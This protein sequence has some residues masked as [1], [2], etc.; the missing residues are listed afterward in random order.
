[1][2]NGQVL[3]AMLSRASVRK[4]RQ[5]PVS[6]EVLRTIVR[7]G[8]QAPF[9]G[10]MYSVIVATER[11][12]R[13]RL[14][15]LF[16]SLVVQAPVFMLI[17]VDF[18]RLE[19]FIA[20]RG[21]SNRADDMSMLFLGIQD[22]SYAG[23]NMVLAAQALGLGSVFLGA[24]PFVAP[25]LAEIF[26]LPPRVYPLVG[27]GL[28]YP[29]ESPAPRPRIPLDLVYMSQSYRRPSAAEIE[30]AMEVMDTGLLREGYYARLHAMIPLESGQETHDYTNY[31]WGEHIARKYGQMKPRGM[32]TMLL[33]Q[34]ISIS[35]TPSDAGA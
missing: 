28:G 23:M 32:R 18:L 16:G 4:F 33:G 5:L 25:Q 22:A 10:Q 14:R 27:L 29:D 31:G 24:A 19:S 12:V 11:S 34:G 1:M 6:E 7:A 20:A 9:A 2:S 13:E 8:Q 15:P 26:Q 21:R 3:S 30:E 35:A 17:C